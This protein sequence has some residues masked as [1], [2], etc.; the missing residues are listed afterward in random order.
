MK[1]ARRTAAA[2]GRK[3]TKRRHRP[4]GHRRTAL[5]GL[6]QASISRIITEVTEALCKQASRT[7]TF[8]VSQQKVTEN[9]QATIAGF[10][11]ATEQ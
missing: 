5:I 4:S 11:N 8:P 3:T 7:I 10:P 9:K 6:S 2:A 1:I